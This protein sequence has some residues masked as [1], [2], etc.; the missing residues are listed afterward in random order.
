MNWSVALF[1]FAC[2]A[3]AAGSGAAI[4]TDARVVGERGRKRPAWATVLSFAGAFVA[5]VGGMMLA[6]IYPRVAGAGGEAGDEG[7]ELLDYWKSGEL[8]SDEYL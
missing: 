6:A 3:C 7:N 4:F 8:K 5:V 2:L 1:V